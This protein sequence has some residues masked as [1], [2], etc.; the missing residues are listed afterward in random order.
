MIH[1]KTSLFTSKVKHPI[2]KFGTGLA[3]VTGMTPTNSED[4]DVEMYDDIWSSIINT[5]WIGSLTASLELWEL[6][7]GIPSMRGPR[8]VRQFKFEFMCQNSLN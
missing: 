1:Q 3:K 8:I 6:N 7:G 4:S 5:D 2:G